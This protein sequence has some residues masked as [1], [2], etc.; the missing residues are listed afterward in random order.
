MFGIVCKFYFI[1]SKIIYNVI[2]KYYFI[3]V[4]GSDATRKY[5]TAFLQDTDLLLF[6]VDA[7]DINKLSSAAS[8]LK[9]LLSDARMDDVPILVVANKQVNI[10]NNTYLRIH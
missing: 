2:V 1:L 10:F 7:S 4:G 9:Q 6:V 5:W 3:L 8:I